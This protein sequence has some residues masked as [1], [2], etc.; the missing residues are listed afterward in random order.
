[1]S[2]KISLTQ[3]NMKKMKNIYDINT[4]I[5][6]TKTIIITLSQLLI[7]SETKKCMPPFTKEYFMW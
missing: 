7:I 6:I 2:N 3:L 5:H 1:M 4:N